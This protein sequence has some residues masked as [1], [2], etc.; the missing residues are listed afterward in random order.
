MLAILGVSHFAFFATP[1]PAFPLPSSAFARP[2]APAQRTSPNSSSGAPS[3]DRLPLR[4]PL[5]SR[6]LP[7]RRSGQHIL[8]GE[9]RIGD[10]LAH[11]GTERI[12][13]ASPVLRLA[14][15]EA[16]CLFVQVAEQVKGLDAHVGALDAPLE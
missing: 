3:Q 1:D 10:A 2:S 4:F 12:H 11:D 14:G 5:R 7:S 16:V 6:S 13:E 8:A 15:I 9:C